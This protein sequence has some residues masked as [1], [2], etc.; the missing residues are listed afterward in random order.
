MASAMALAAIAETKSS[1]AMVASSQ[2][3]AQELETALRA[4]TDGCVWWPLSVAR[5]RSARS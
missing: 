4:H 5:R 2:L 1:V 3:A